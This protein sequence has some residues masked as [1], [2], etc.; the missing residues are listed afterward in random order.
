VTQPPSQ[1][2]DTGNP[3]LA[4]GPSRLETGS[5]SSPAGTIGMITVRTAS[6]T[7]TL[8]A[9]EADVREWATL[10]GELADTL[11][12]SGGGIVPATAMDVAA[13][14]RQQQQLRRNGQRPPR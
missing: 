2:F 1:L 12:G 5:V 4:Q 11:G 7:L 14:T 9:A 10:L 8:F 6:T 3:L 13:L